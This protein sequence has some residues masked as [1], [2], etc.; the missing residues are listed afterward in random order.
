MN[1]G[2]L[3]NLIQIAKLTGGKYIFFED[4][5]PAAVLMGYGD[6]ED[7]MVEKLAGKMAVDLKR[8]EAVNEQITR[9]QVEDL[10]EQVMK[11]DFMITPQTSTFA[12]NPDIRVEPIEPN[13]EILD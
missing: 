12:G 1:D 9:A 5:K 3:K 7:L 13:N 8:V 4:G 2:Q 6:F 11:E 10:R